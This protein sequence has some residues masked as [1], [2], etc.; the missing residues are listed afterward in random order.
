VRQRLT[1]W[2]HECM[3]DIPLAVRYFLEWGILA[4]GSKVKLR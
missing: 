4:H 3:V 1:L 2:L